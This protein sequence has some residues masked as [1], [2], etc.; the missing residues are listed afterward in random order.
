[1]SAPDPGAATKLEG[2]TRVPIAQLGPEVPDQASRVIRGEVTITWPYSSVNQKL[3]FLLAEPDVRL[4]RNKGQVRVEL[5][6]SSARAVAELELG[7][8]DEVTLS[9][10]GVEW[11]KDDSRTRAPGTRLEWQLNYGEKVVLQVRNASRFPT[12]RLLGTP[13]TTCRRN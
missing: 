6:G 12:N 2:R 1:M 9:L 13:L 10:D 3:A 7:G 11:T 4:R 5:H 8:G